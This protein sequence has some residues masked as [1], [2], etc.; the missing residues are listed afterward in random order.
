V[1]SE[2]REDSPSG[3]SVKMEED[4]PSQQWHNEKA[5]H[6]K[7]IQNLIVKTISAK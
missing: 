5:L 4:Y 7:Q 1:E 3:K 2:V 6:D